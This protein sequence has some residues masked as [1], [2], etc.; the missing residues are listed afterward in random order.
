MRKILIILGVVVLIAGACTGTFF[1]TRHHTFAEAY[2]KGKTIGT[3]VGYSKGYSK[4]HSDG[5]N[6]GWNAGKGAKS[7]SV[8]QQP[9]TSTTPKHCTSF[10]Y[11]IENQFTDTDCR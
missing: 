2:S 7:F 10:T 1:L 5:Y 8:A 11:G 6:S 3:K 4:G 9:S